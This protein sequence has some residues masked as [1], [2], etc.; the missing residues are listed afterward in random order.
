MTKTAFGTVRLVGGLLHGMRPWLVAGVVGGAGAV[1]VPP[2]SAQTPANGAVP[3]IS[4]TTEIQSVP[5][6]RSSPVRIE[7][8][9]EEYRIGT[10]DLLEVQ[11]LGFR[12]C[13]VK[14]VSTPRA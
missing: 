9:E 5:S 11:V 12:T 1:L 14:R 7:P 2:A 8:V 6:E 13:A 4:A 10:Q 3:A